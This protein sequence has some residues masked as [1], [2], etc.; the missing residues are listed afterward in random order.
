MILRLKYFGMLAEVIQKEEETIDFNQKNIQELDDL[1]QSI[2]P[3]L[4]TM[5]YQ[6]ALN[7]S[8]VGVGEEA[9]LKDNDEIA[10][11]PPFAGG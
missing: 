7:H 9:L 3:K 10:V 1:L 11:L 2:Y 5:E 4:G 6:F 8:L